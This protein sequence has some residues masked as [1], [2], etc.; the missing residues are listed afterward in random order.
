MRHLRLL[1]LPA[2]LLL[3]G[4]WSAHNPTSVH[5]DQRSCTHNCNIGATGVQ[6]GGP[7]GVPVY[8]GY[9]TVIYHHW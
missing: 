9:G 3:A 7:G 4:C 2:V 6:G 8:R 5:N 1:L